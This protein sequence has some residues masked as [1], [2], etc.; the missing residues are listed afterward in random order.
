MKNI[1]EK[2]TIVERR[3]ILEGLQAAKKH[4]AK[5]H[6]KQRD[7]KTDVFICLAISYAHDAGEIT[8]DQSA[9]TKDYI[10]RAIRK[11]DTVNQLMMQQLGITVTHHTKAVQKYRKALLNLMIGGFD[12]VWLS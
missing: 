2:Y 7:G 11:K 4:L 10:H 1:A 12:K 9:I 8:A 6:E 5:S 3:D